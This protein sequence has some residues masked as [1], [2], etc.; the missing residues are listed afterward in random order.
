MGQ[1]VLQG[2]LHTLEFEQIFQL[3]QGNLKEALVGELKAL[4]YKPKSRKGYLYASGELP[5]MLIAHMDTVHRQLVQHICYSEDGCV[6]MSPEGIGGDDRAGVYMILRILQ[7]AKCHVLFCEDEEVGGQGA[8]KFERSSIRPEVNYLIELDRR[9][10]ND[11]VFYGCN[12]REFIKFI[13]D[14]GFREA[15]GSF[16]DI[17]VVAPHLDV[18]AVNISA[19]YYNEHR[20]HEYV[21]LDQMEENDF[22]GSGNRSD[23][24][25]AVC[26]QGVVLQPLDRRLLGQGTDL[27]E[28]AVQL[29]EGTEAD[30][31]AVGQRPPDDGK[32]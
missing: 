29:P 31:G 14:F 21:R 32:P 25:R 2:Q 4:G 30:D 13:C 9:G 27:M 17:S 23:Q 5:V 22:P 3:S 26:L 20:Q 7:E 11:A 15:G 19:G 16:S 18:A 6:M 1:Q 24:H 10:G 8:R 12:N 28:Y